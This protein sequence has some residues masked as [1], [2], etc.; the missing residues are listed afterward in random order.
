MIRVL[1]TDD[2]KLVRQGLRLLIERDL[3]LRVIGE[4]GDGQ[5]SVELAQRLSPDIVLM[6]L[7]MPRLGGMEAT[8]R[9]CAGTNTPGVIIV[10]MSYDELLV[11]QALQKG[12]RGYV[13]KNDMYSELLPAIHAVH[14]GGSYF[15]ACIAP[16]VGNDGS[17]LP[18]EN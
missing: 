5:A 17:H 4:A 18:Q 3:E 6:D 16:L 14:G 7:K 8:G 2:D 10:A 1:I 12:A 11:R 9:I 15:S 13:A